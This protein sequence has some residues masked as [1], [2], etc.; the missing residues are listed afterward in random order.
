MIGSPI[1]FQ[2]APPQPSSKAFATWTYVFVGG[3]EASQNGLGLLIPA[4]LTL[5]SAISVS[6]PKNCLNHRGLN[7]RGHGGHRGLR[8]P[9]SLCLAR[10]T[11]V[12]ASNNQVFLLFSV[13]SVPSV[14]ECFLPS[15]KLVNAFC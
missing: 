6:I 7:D 14:V 4:K 13:P 11:L 8:L 12:P 10:K 2:T 5:R 1:V 15:E 9:C 3:P